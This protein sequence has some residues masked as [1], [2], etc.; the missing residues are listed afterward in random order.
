MLTLCTVWPGC[1]VSVVACAQAMG[2]PWAVLLTKHNQR[3]LK[4][5]LC[6][7]R[8]VF[9]AVRCVACGAWVHTLMTMSKICSYASISY[10]Y[11]CV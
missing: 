5:G 10:H 1:V 6:T 2:L 7:Y 8:E 9:Q 4:T 11:S 3:A